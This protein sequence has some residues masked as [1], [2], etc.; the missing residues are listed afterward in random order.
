MISPFTAD[1]MFFNPIMGAIQMQAIE[2]KFPLVL[3]IIL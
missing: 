1:G 3:I 2:Q